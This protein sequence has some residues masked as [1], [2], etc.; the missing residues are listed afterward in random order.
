M[1]NKNMISHFTKNAIF[2]DIN[3]NNESVFIEIRQEIIFHQ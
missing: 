2:N 1:Q 3:A